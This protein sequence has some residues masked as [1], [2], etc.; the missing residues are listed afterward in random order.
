MKPGSKDLQVAYE[1]MGHSPMF[2]TKYPYMK[3]SDILLI[4]VGAFAALFG[5]FNEF[6][7]PIR[8]PAK[9]FL[10]LLGLLAIFAVLRH[11]I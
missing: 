6:F 2:G 8:R 9:I 3:P 11:R 4:S 1:R 5:L 10:V 7:V